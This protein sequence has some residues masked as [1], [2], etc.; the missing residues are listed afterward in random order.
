VIRNMLRR[1]AAS[2]WLCM[3]FEFAFFADQGIL[4][5]VLP[6]SF[7]ALPVNELCLLFWPNTYATSAHFPYEISLR[8]FHAFVCAVMRF[9]YKILHNF[10][11]RFSYESSCFLLH[12]LLMR[13]YAFYS[14]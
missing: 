14:A 12:N 6:P 10:H 3:K 5:R 7:L 13:F 4:I 8:D 1:G 11:I 2:S 9:P